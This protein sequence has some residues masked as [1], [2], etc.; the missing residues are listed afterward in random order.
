MH[1]SR[2][3]Q[4]VRC[5]ANV[6]WPAVPPACTCW[7]GDHC[8]AAAHPED[9]C[10]SGCGH[11]SRP[12]A[13]A[14]SHLLAPNLPPATL[15]RVT[16][17]RRLWSCWACCAPRHCTC[18]RSGPQ[19]WRHSC[20][21]RPTSLTPACEFEAPYALRLFMCVGCSLA[22]LSAAD[23]L[24]CPQLCR[25]PKLRPQLSTFAALLPYPS[26][27]ASLLVFPRTDTGDCA[28][29]CWAPPSCSSASS[30][31]PS[32][33]CRHQPAPPPRRPG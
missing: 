29:R 30:S 5:D 20:S 4:K 27:P 3:Q 13:A 12:P 6:P 32:S 2:R 10:T 33:R 31:A 8:L 17:W 15:C 16:C 1:H 22:V 14:L 18:R 25:P 19:A 23:T 11:A 9:L 7:T 21:L 26:P 24:R 28:S